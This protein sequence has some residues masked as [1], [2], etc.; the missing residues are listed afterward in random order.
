MPRAYRK[1]IKKENTQLIYLNQVLPSPEIVLIGAEG[2]TTNI[3][4]PLLLSPRNKR[5]RSKL[6]QGYT[7][8]LSK[9]HLLRYIH[10]YPPGGVK[11]YR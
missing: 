6:Y 11:A 1:T 2:A 8:V 7:E 3:R 4:K 5:F 9:Q 10:R